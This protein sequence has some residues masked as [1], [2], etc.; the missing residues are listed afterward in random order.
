MA[1][2]GPDKGGVG[3]VGIVAVGVAPGVDE[4]VWGCICFD[5][6]GFGLEVPF[7]GGSGGESSRAQKVGEKSGCIGWS[8]D[9]GGAGSADGV[10]VV[11][12][13]VAVAGGLEGGDLRLGGGG[14]AVPANGARGTEGKAC[15]DADDGDDGEEFDEGEGK[16]LTQRTPRSERGDLIWEFEMRPAVAGRA[17]ARNVE[18]EKRKG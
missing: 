16:L 15:E 3:S 7:A 9:R 2:G 4:G 18:F 5:H 13:E 17:Y 11:I 8:G 10:G 1:C 6:G 14:G 12:G